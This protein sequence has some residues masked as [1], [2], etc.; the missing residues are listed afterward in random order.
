MEKKIKSMP[1]VSIG[2][3]LKTSLIAEPSISAFVGTTVDQNILAGDI[4]CLG[5]A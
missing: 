5:T 4:A 1:L 3:K 2:S